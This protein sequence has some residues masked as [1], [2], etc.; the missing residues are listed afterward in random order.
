MIP[1]RSRFSSPLVTH[2]TSREGRVPAVT[3]KMDYGDGHLSYLSSQHSKAAAKAPRKGT[4]VWPLALRG[5]SGNGHRGRHEPSPA[6]LAHSLD[7]A[8]RKG[9]TAA[10]PPPGPWNPRTWGRA[11]GDPSADPA[12]RPPASQTPGPG[13]RTGGRKDSNISQPSS[14][15]ASSVE[16]EICVCVFLGRFPRV[17]TSCLRPS[18]PVARPH[19]AAGG[20][21]DFVRSQGTCEPGRWV[22]KV[23][24]FL[25]CHAF[26]SVPL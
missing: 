8:G 16:T 6:C 13:N 2:A 18:L 21:P 22:R 12:R 24:L 3:S 26:L 23:S 17:N 4:V 14:L 10:P 11:R 9:D 25:P 1:P 7:E 19:P 15:S 20:W 5:D